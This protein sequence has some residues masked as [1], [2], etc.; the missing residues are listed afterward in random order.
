MSKVEQIAQRYTADHYGDLIVPDK[1][2]YNERMKLWEVFLRSTY[3][4]IIKDEQTNDVL[5]RFLDLRKLGILKIDNEL[6]VIEATSTE[7]CES[8][9]VSRIEM[10]KA[11]SEQIVI[12]ASSDVFGKIAVGE[13]VLNPFLLIFD[14]LARHRDTFTILDEEINAQQRSSRLR[15]YLQLLEELEIVKKV[16]QG[17]SY[18]NRYV[19]ILEES[20]TKGLDMQTALISHVIER[21]YSALRQ[22]FGITQL[23][24]Y[25]HLANAFYWP[26]LDAERLVHTTRKSLMQ[27]F[28][29][30]YGKVF[31]WG[32]DLKLSHLI[33]QG[34]IIEENGY[35]T[36]DKVR[37]ESMLTLKQNNMR[38]NPPI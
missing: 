12:K 8:Q 5:V 10:W 2:M 32:F 21:R 11:Q 31:T 26:S 33:K 29:D 25:V 13:Y 15:Q 18:G 4:R 9:L 7:S 27:R 16:D 19:G 3:P 22:V 28:R 38:L 17:Y 35:L 36:G 20:K 14:R 34:A 37:F 24:P 23:E 1:P 6:Q 30:F